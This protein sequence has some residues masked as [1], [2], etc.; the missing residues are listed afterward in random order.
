MAKK[1]KLPLN[2]RKHGNKYHFHGRI[3]KDLLTHPFF[4]NHQSGFYYK[5]LGTDNLLEARRRRD[6]ILAT[7]ELLREDTPEETYDVWVKKYREESEQFLKDNPDALNPECPMEF[8]DF[9][10]D[11]LLDKAIKQYGRDQETGNP[12][13]IPEDIQIRIDALMGKNRKI[14]RGSMRYT[15]KKLLKEREAR[16]GAKGSSAKTLMKIKRGVDWYLEQIG[17]GDVKLEG[18]E[19]EDVN[20]IVTRQLLS[21]VAPK[22]ID[23]HLYGLRQVWKRA[24]QNN[25]SMEHQNPFIKH[26]LATSNAQSYCPF[27]WDEIRQLWLKAESPEMKLAIQIG[28]TT[29]ARISEVATLTTKYVNG[30]GGLCYAIK[31]SEKGKTEHASRVLP[32]H[33]KLAKKLGEGWVYPL[34]DRTLSRTFGALKDEVI[35][36]WIDPLTDRQRKLGF[37]S[38]RSSVASYLVNEAGYP[39]TTASAYTGHKADKKTHSAIV[40]YIRTPDLE[41]K[42][43][44]CLALPWVFD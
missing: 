25:P 20:E 24:F 28:A 17:E 21:G 29:G 16:A 27:S 39:E 7:F 18:V 41:K 1:K 44:M 8:K 11:V 22:T 31:L 4:E 35:A 10:L 26:N 6:E 19:W 13:Q 3:P 38:F 43:E 12:K 32:V 14:Y 5:S 36:D 37:H 15:L 9:E 2:I 40:T 23:G 42:L 33:P 30:F 34:S